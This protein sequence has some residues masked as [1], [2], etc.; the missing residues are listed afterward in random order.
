MSII[1]DLCKDWARLHAVES[2]N[3]IAQLH[4]TILIPNLKV[5]NLVEFITVLHKS[6]QCEL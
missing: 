3:T 1:Y 4:Q 6:K 5:E 2:V